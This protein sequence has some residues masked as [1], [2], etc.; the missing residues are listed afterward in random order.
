MYG[1]DL[2]CVIN[3]ND[4]RVIGLTDCTVSVISDDAHADA[5][6]HKC[7]H[8]RMHDWHESNYVAS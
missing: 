8:T 7:T 6:L 2:A 3:T 4:V 5:T 1:C